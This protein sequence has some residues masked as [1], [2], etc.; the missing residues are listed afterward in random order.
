MPQLLVIVF[1][2]DNREGV[3]TM[4]RN[5]KRAAWA[6]GGTT[7]AA[8]LMVMVG[9]WQVLMGIAAIAEDEVF[10]S[11]PNYLLQ[12]DLTTWGWTHLI[13]GALAVVVGAFIFSDKEW[14]RW[15]G[16]LLAILSATAQFFW[17]PYQPLWSIVVIAIDVFIIWSLAATNTRAESEY[18][19]YRAAEEPAW[20]DA[21]TQPGQP[22][23]NPT[24]TMYDKQESARRPSPTETS[25]Q[26]KDAP[27]DSA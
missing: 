3:E 17:M 24:R 4:A 23:A 19:G 10:I 15:V 14:A 18:E 22:F 7:F 12:L 20:S 27:P 16:I 5:T 1:P 21:N 26:S 25:A 13:L 2:M 9:A 8:C 11:T 6:A